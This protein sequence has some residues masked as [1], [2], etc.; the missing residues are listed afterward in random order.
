MSEK[1][2]QTC[3]DSEFQIH[4]L[5]H[6]DSDLVESVMVCQLLM[7]AACQAVPLLARSDGG[8]QI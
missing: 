8:E 6:S 7:V 3:T 2:E 4:S 1:C 5:A